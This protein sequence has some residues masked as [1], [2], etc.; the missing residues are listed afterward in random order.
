MDSG[1]HYARERTVVGF[2]EVSLVNGQDSL[3]TDTINSPR[4]YRVDSVQAA[5]VGKLEEK[6]YKDVGSICS[7][8]ERMSHIFAL[9]NERQGTLLTQN[10]PI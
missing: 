7:E 4:L 6:N 8:E 1:T 10:M 3:W 2:E 9:K 5:E